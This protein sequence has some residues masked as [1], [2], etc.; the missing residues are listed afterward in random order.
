MTHD[1]VKKLFR[2]MMSCYPN[3]KP[4]SLGDSIEVWETI[5]KDY[6]DEQIA[7]ALNA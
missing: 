5:L 3:F 7:L 6:S 4:T 2:V 1:G